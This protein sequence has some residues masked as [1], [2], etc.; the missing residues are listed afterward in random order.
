PVY[1][2]KRFNRNELEKVKEK[3]E[4]ENS[5]LEFEN[6]DSPNINIIEDLKESNVK[7]VIGNFEGRLKE[8]LLENDIPI[9]NIKLPGDK[10]VKFAK[11]EDIES[12]KKVNKEGFISWIKNYKKR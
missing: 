4:I 7:A 9:I 8:E 12:G 11:I 10:D 2:V 1:V 6:V 3:Y 5:L